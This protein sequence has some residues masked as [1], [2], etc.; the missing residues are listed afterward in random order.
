[1]PYRA[2]QRYGS[3]HSAFRKAL[4]ARSTRSR[5]ARAAA[6]AAARRAPRRK[7][8]KRYVVRGPRPGSG[9]QQVGLARFL[10]HYKPLPGYSKMELALAKHGNIQLNEWRRFQSYERC[11]LQPDSGKC[12]WLGVPAK[13]VQGT[14]VTEPSTSSDYVPANCDL[15]DISR[16]MMQTYTDRA[17]GAYT[18]PYSDLPSSSGDTVWQPIGDVA[19]VTSATTQ[20]VGVTPRMRGIQVKNNWVEVLIE[21]VS[22]LDAFVEQ[23][24]L[25]YRR[26]MVQGVWGAAYEGNPGSM[27]THA[28]YG[29]GFVGGWNTTTNLPTATAADND[30]EPKLFIPSKQYPATDHLHPYKDQLANIDVRNYGSR[31]AGCLLEQYA[32]ICINHRMSQAYAQPLMTPSQEVTNTVGFVSPLALLCNPMNDPKQAWPRS[33]KM[34]HGYRL[35]KVKKAH[36]LKPGASMRVRIPAKE[37]FYQD[38]ADLPRVADRE[39]DLVMSKR[40]PGVTGGLAANKLNYNTVSRTACSIPSNIRCH[41]FRVFGDMISDKSK[42]EPEAD[43]DYQT[44]STR[45]QFMIRRSM[46]VRLAQ[47]ERPK[48][49]DPMFGFDASVSW[50]NQEAIND[51]TDAPMVVGVAGDVA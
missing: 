16:K 50:T 35:V 30:N 44:G 47:F 36:C 5:S 6:V 32:R 31:F 40:L 10:T 21:N 23:Y 7:A 41:F 24:V 48:E 38:F 15:Y 46:D 18:N 29:G 1:M 34:T 39:A 25:E 2:K 51:E 9:G 3:K 26:P 27:L 28:D 17:A 12:Q 45:L 42:T 4:A 13:L 49:V 8:S 33:V 22:S 37:A 20:Q 11:H 14:T 19:A 43:T